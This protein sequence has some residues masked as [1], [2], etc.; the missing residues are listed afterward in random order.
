MRW[1]RGRF[2]RRRS[3][4]GVARLVLILRYA[5]PWP[6]VWARDVTWLP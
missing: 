1:L 3:G 6:Y 5:D 2:R 4:L